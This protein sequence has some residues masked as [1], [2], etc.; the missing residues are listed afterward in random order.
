MQKSGTLQV[1]DDSPTGIHQ[2]AGL[3]TE[4]VVAPAAAHTTF[5]ETGRIAT[6]P[7]R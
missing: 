6:G 2:L 5:H 1:G 3:D 4:H 7:G